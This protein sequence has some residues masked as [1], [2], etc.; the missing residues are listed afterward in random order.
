M[1][2]R[3]TPLASSVPPTGVAVSSPVAEEKAAPVTPRPTSPC[4]AERKAPRA[5]RAAGVRS[6]YAN[7]VETNRTSALDQSNPVFRMPVVT[8]VTSNPI[9]RSANNSPG[10]TAAATRVARRGVVPVRW[11]ASNATS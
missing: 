8:G 11:V 3:T 10:V 9:S 5:V 2:T 6:S 4:P 7:S 1:A